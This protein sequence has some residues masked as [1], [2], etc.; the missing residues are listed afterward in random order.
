MIGLRKD[1]YAL[2][3]VQPPL[4]GGVRGWVFCEAIVEEFSFHRRRF[5]FTPRKSVG[6]R[7]TPFFEFLN[8]VFGLVFD[9]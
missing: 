1:E 9:S 7:V 2:G 4:P 3:N 8:N 5:F 6:V